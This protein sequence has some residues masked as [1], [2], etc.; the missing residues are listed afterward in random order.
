MADILLNL[1][2]FVVTPAVLIY[3]GRAKGK[4]ELITAFR[5]FTCLSNVLCSLTALVTAVSLIAGEMPE[6]VWI[7][8]YVGT[9]GVTVT[10]VTVFVYL[11]PAVGKDWVNV[12]IK[13]IVN[14]FMHVVTPLLALSTFCVLERRPMT[15]GQAL[16]G[17]LPVALYGPLYLYK[18]ILAPE[19]KRWP[20]FYG[21]NKNG[22][23]KLSFLFMLIGNFLLCM[24]IMAIMNA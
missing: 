3:V 18:T 16:W 6:W 4:D 1:L 15:F 13:G 24:V 22:K 7:L 17:L 10:M 21:F 8:K 9:A 19:A 5:Y 12:L 14:S 11:S 2:I 20:D 23:W